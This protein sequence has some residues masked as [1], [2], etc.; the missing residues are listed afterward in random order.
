M[1]DKKI[2]TSNRVFKVKKEEDIKLVLLLEVLKNNME[3]I[4]RK[5]LAHVSSNGKDENEDDNV[6]IIEQRGLLTDIKE[7]IDP[8]VQK[9]DLLAYNKTTNQAE[10]C[11]IRQITYFNRQ[12]S[13]CRPEKRGGSRTSHKNIKTT[14][15][16]IDHVK[17]LKCRSSHYGRNKI[18]RGYLPPE[19]SVRKLYNMWCN[20]R[21]FNVTYYL[22]MPRLPGQ[23]ESTIENRT[24]LVTMWEHGTS[25]DEIAHIVG[26]SMSCHGP[27]ELVQVSPRFSSQEYITI[28]EDVLLPTTW[29][30]IRGTNLCESLVRSMPRR[31]QDC[32]ENQGQHTKY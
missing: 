26:L 29:E 14:D 32:I 18:V 24:K 3:L 31:L 16:I 30:S 20:I 28:L 19:L 8:L 11:N 7:V 4:L 10:Q 22:N 13:S 21:K 23:R 27:G 15:S 9:S 2:I 12:E 17:S 25:K 5:R 1:L 6:K